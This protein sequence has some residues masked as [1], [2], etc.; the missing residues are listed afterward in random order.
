MG[1]SKEADLCIKDINVSRRHAEFTWKSRFG[2]QKKSEFRRF[3]TIS[4]YFSDGWGV[5]N[6]SDNGVWVNKIPL[7]KVSLTGL[8]FSIQYLTSENSYSANLLPINP[9]Y[10]RSYHMYHIWS[11]YC[12]KVVSFS[13]S[14]FC[15]GT[16]IALKP[17]DLVVLSNLGNLFSW[18]FHLGENRDGSKY[19]KRVG[20]QSDEGEDQPSSKRQKVGLD[21]ERTRGRG[22]GSASRELIHILQK[23]KEAAEVR[24]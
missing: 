3:K 9:M 21:S 14:H 8:R 23:K 22:E 15:Q 13:S 1:R 2:S 20:F 7:A 18:R 17:G 11:S 16:S 6:Y 10:H 24:F 5:T 12:P 19:L 4:N